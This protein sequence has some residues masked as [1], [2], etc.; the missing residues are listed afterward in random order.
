MDLQLKKRNKL[1]R[2][3]KHCRESPVQL[4]MINCRPDSLRFFE[5]GLRR[6]SVGSFPEQRLVIEL[7]Y[8]PQIPEDHVVLLNDK[9]YN[10]VTL[11]LECY[12]DDS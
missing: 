11:T 10:N 9:R 1:N 6:R 7:D 8:L 2:S 4:I 3:V 12:M 5:S